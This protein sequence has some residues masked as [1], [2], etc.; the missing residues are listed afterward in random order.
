MATRYGPGNLST[1]TIGGSDLLAVVREARVET[2]SVTVEGRTMARSGRTPQRVKKGVWVRTTNLSTISSGVR[3]SHLHVE[4]LRIDDVELAPSFIEG[5]L[6][7]DF[8]S[9]EA[10]GIGEAWL[11]PQLVE[12]GYRFKGVCMADAGSAATLK[13]LAASTL[14]GPATTL[15]LRINGLDIEIPMLVRRIEQVATFADVQRF[16]VELE[17]RSPDSGAYPTSPTTTT[18][19]LGWSLNDPN[20]ART[21]LVQT[22]GSVPIEASGSVIPDRFLVSFRNSELVRESYVFRSRGEVLWT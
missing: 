14:D 18:T 8:R 22:T 12:K 7:G 19:L 10:S 11:N 5:S 17:G 13:A 4:Q 15:K 16:E 3:V 20:T 9:V 6:F 1:V 2:R 21:F